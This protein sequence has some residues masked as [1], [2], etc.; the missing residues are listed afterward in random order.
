MERRAEQP[1]L[2]ERLR[3]CGLAL[4]VV[5]VFLPV[6][7]AAMRIQFSSIVGGV[8]LAVHGAL[9]SRFMFRRATDSDSSLYGYVISHEHTEY[10]RNARDR[11]VLALGWCNIAGF[12][13]LPFLVWW[14]HA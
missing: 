10:E 3:I 1:V 11:L 8:F 12:G 13:V 6:S 2:G 7:M 5:A 14:L 9:L 4:L